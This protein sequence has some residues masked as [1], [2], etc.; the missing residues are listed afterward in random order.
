MQLNERVGVFAHR[1]ASAG[2]ATMEF[3]TILVALGGGS[4]SAGAIELACRLARRFHSHLEALHA[5]PD[6]RDMVVALGDGFAT[7]MAG[8]ILEQATR[9][10][11]AAAEKARA[12][13]DAA[14]KRH[15]LEIEAA[16]PPLGTDPALRHRASAAWRE[17]TGF[18]ATLIADRAR[19]FDLL[20]LGR[21]GRV[22][23]EP[24]GESIEEALLSSGRPVLIAPADPPKLLGESVALAWNDSPEAARA[25]TAALPFLEHARAVHV[26]SLGDKNADAL[27]QHLAWY[28]VRATAQAVRP[29]EKVGVGE[30]LLA[31]ARE[32]GADLLVMGG[33][34]HAPWRQVL[35]GGATRHV[36]GTSRLP[37][38]MAH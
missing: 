28:G 27:A 10:A 14:M 24:H 8:T 33:Y 12:L 19:L 32:H 34:G 6:P 29:V 21:S 30:L 1:E 35:F 18:G 11:A 22:V 36:L 20:V 25:V 5:R 13:F 38:L 37:I 4:A 23:G 9:D 2:G 15:A 3:R 16:P 31:A 26:L 17:E 7:P